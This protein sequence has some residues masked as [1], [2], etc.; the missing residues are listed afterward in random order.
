[1]LLKPTARRACPI[2]HKRHAQPSQVRVQLSLRHESS[3][4]GAV[5]GT[6]VGLGLILCV[7]KAG[8]ETPLRRR[9]FGNAG[10]RWLRAL[11]WSA[12]ARRRRRLRRRRTNRRRLRIRALCHISQYA[13]QHL[14]L[15][16]L[17]IVEHHDLAPLGLQRVGRVGLVTERAELGSLAA[18]ECNDDDKLGVVA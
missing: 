3:G 4:A 2:R 16:L 18:N 5:H 1:M 17:G 11:A 10:R 15:V 12:L 6:R 8:R 9:A 7:F 13:L 14:E